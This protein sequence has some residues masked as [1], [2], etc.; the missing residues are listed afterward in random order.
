[1]KKTQKKSG[2]LARKMKMLKA[3]AAAQTPQ[4]SEKMRERATTIR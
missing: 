2:K 4:T 1:M 3:Y